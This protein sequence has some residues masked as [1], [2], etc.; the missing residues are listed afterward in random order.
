MKRLILPCLEWMGKQHAVPVWLLVC[1][2]NMPKVQPLATTGSAR[3]AVVVLLFLSEGVL[4]NFSCECVGAYWMPEPCLLCFKLKSV[5]TRYY[6]GKT[7][8]ICSESTGSWALFIIK[9]CVCKPV[10]AS[11]ATN[12]QVEIFSLFRKGFPQHG[13]SLHVVKGRF[14]KI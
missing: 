8:N 3:G 14:C 1:H 9:M 5:N 10:K 4:A 11:V 13:K 12:S 6:W 7:E 2:C